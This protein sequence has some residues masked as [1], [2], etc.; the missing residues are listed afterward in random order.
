MKIKKDYILFLLL[1]AIIVF[2]IYFL[3]NSSKSS[4]PIVADDV[5]PTY[6]SEQIPLLEDLEIIINNPKF[7]E[8]KYIQSFFNPVVVERRGRVNPFMPFVSEEKEE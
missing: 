8:M 5:R 3:A 6:L 7:Q 2:T 1:F 4:V